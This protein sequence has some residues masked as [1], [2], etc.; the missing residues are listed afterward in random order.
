VNACDFDKD[1]DLDIFRGG[2][3][4]STEYPLAPESYLLENTSNIK[5]IKTALFKDI[6]PAE[7]KNIGMV[8]AALWTDYDNDSWMD[9]MLV[10]EF[11]PITI[12]KNNKGK[13]FTKINVPELLNTNGWWNSLTGGDFDNDGDIDYVLGNL[14]LNSKLKASVN[15]PVMVCAKDFDDNG[16]MDA[17]LTAYNGNREYLIHPRGILIDQMIAMR[18][19]FKSFKEYGE[20]TFLE[21]IP[22][23]DLKGSVMIKSQLFASSY[24]K[25]KRNGKFQIRTL[26][27][28]GQTAPMYGIVVKDV[29]QDGNLDIL[30]VGNDYSTEVLTGR[31]DAGI[32]TYLQGDG[33]GNFKNVPVTKSNFFVKGNAKALAEITLKDGTSLLLTTQINDKLL[34]FKQTDRVSD[35]INPKRKE[36]FYIGSGYLS[37]SGLAHSRKPSL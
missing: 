18:R 16:T 23:V 15:Q 6:T 2:R 17:L 27:I 28:E 13:L 20:T 35:K 33:K 9:L 29:N 1:G 8:T 34:A 37:Q 5:N 36:E 11:M 25:N 7:L 12:F 31:Y 30:S 19:R 22:E 10:G 32:G 26:P 14:G 24:L 4:R 21:T 3:V